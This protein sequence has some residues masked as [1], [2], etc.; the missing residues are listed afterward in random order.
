MP[1]RIGDVLSAGC[2]ELIKKGAQLVTEVGDIAF[3]LKD[4]YPDSVIYH[5]DADSQYSFAPPD[6]AKKLDRFFSFFYDI[7]REISS[8]PSVFR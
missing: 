4:K 5:T 6:H 7:N 8:K 2:L 1:G 3:A